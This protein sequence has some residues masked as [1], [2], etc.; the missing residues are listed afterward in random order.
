[1]HIIHTQKSTHRQIIEGFMAEYERIRAKLPKEYDK[2]IKPEELE[3][4]ES[5]ELAQEKKK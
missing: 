5:E 3:D 2:E 1:M 4:E